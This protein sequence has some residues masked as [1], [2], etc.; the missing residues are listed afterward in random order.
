VVGTAYSASLASSGGV[1][2]ITWSVAKGTLPA[3]LTLGA[4]GAISGI[5]TTAAIATFSLTVTD[6]STPS[7]SQT[8]VLSLT[9]ASASAC[10]TGNES[11]L[12]GQ[13]AFG[14][15]GQT[16]DGFFGVVG[17]FTADGIG[18]IT[19]GHV[20]ANGQQIVGNG[21]GVQSS[22]ITPSGSS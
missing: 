1:G 17:S 10:G 14:M 9:V 11:A 13:Y 8:Q 4:A 21:L 20:D 6:S 15:T 7:Q 19:A 22:T 18:N 3:G 16:G 12:K 5:P 2:T